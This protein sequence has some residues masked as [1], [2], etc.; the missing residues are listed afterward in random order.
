MVQSNA[1]IKHF[2][3]WGCPVYVPDSRLQDGKGNLHKW[4][5]RTQSGMYFGIFTV[6]ANSVALVL[7][8]N[9]VYL[10]PQFHCVFDEHF[11]TVSHMRNGTVPSKW[12]YLVERSSEEVLIEQF[13]VR[14]TWL[15]RDQPP[16]QTPRVHQYLELLPLYDPSPDEPTDNLS[17][18]PE[19]V[20][21]TETLS[22]EMTI[23][24][25]TELGFV[26]PEPA[27][28]GYGTTSPRTAPTNEPSIIPEQIVQSLY[29]IPDYQSP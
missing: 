20:L 7:N 24:E 9:T 25:G 17:G 18:L 14:N 13:L 21:I 11:T 23:F 8:P 6:R 1:G 29:Y 5:P 27:H 28:K 4:D 2:R 10:S 16:S 12:A 19:S 22:K 3:N 15:T 26:E